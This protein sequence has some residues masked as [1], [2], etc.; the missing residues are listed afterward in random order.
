ML[1]MNMNMVT[2]CDNNSNKNHHVCGF[3]PL[4]WA[5][6]PPKQVGQLEPSWGGMAGE[7]PKKWSANIIE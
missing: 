7:T 5:T 1:D 4:C 2:I 3:Q 6:H